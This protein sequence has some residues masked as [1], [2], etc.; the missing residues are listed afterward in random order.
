MGL[1][2]I[3]HNN[4][5]LLY[6]LDAPANVAKLGREFAAGAQLRHGIPGGVDR[7]AAD[8]EQG[9]NIEIKPKTGEDTAENM[10]V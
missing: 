7:L 3:W 1:L 4:S 9:R 10:G 8:D 6:V 2:V 5:F